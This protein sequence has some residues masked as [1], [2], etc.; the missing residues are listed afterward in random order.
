MRLV[1]E[2]YVAGNVAIA[3]QESDWKR[4]TDGSVVGTLTDLITGS[5]HRV[6][7]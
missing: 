6:V 2:K 5:R 7:V 3:R 1:I 4:A